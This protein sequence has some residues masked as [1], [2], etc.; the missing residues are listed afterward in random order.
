MDSDSDD[1]LMSR[2]ASSVMA[3]AV[4]PAED[5]AH[6]GQPHAA[7]ACTICR[8]AFYCNEVLL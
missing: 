2:L 6:C 1:E 8:S 4:A 7:T 3:R 5:C